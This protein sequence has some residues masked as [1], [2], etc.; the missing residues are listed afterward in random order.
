V[1]LDPRL[2]SVELLTLAAMRAKQRRDSQTDPYPVV[3]L[4]MD[5]EPEDPDAADSPSGIYLPRK[6]ASIEEWENSPLVQGFRAQ[7]RA[8][9]AGACP[10]SGSS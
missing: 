6:C 4:G 3:W 5:G 2:M 7:L 9:G 1:A 8:P 10:S